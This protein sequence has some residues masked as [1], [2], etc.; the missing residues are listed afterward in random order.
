[1][2]ARLVPRSGVGVRRRQAPQRGSEA[3]RPDEARPDRARGRRLRRAASEL[4]VPERSPMRRSILAAALLAFAAG[5]GGSSKPNF[6]SVP[7]ARTFQ[8]VDFKP[9]TPVAAGKA[10]KVSFVIRQPD[11][12]PLTSFRRGPGPHTGV[13]L[14]FVRKDLAAIV[15]R[16]P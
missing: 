2:A 14:I 13:H 4:P 1:D 16:H 15:H 3:D 8:I 9:T 6:P 7:A 10:A 11:G 5:C 12:K